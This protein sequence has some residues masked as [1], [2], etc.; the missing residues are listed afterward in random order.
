MKILSIISIIIIS[1]FLLSFI[2]KTKKPIISPLP[3]D[4]HTIPIKLNIKPTLIPPAIGLKGKASY[5]SRAG[6][7]GCSD[8]LTMA[9][10]DILDDNALTVAYNRAPLNSMVKITNINNGK[11]IYAKVT[12]TGGFERHGRIIDLTIGTK[13]ALACSDICNIEVEAEK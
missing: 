12:D 6:C 11:T 4:R 2:S 5:Y 13:E 3:V 8:T 7:L 1:I 9:N 10:G